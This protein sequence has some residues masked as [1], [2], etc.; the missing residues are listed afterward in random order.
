MSRRYS[1]TQRKVRASLDPQVWKK[2]GRQPGLCFTVLF[3]D[4][5]NNILKYFAQCPYQLR[6]KKVSNL[7]QK[8]NISLDLE[9]LPSFS[10]F[11]LLSVLLI[12][13]KHFVLPDHS[14]PNQN[15]SLMPFFHQFITPWN[16]GPH[17]VSTDRTML[18]DPLQQILKCKHQTCKVSFAKSLSCTFQPAVQTNSDAYAHH[19]PQ[20]HPRVPFDLIV[21]TKIQMDTESSSSWHSFPTLTP[22]DCLLISLERVPREKGG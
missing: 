10:K 12:T 3:E 4:Y 22:P 1:H 14:F 2:Q 11:I 18:K 16:P 5:I 7:F 13:T 8:G 15:P 6:K 20:T 9:K 17:C 21:Q 19:I